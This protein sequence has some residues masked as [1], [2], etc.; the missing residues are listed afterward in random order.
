VEKINKLACIQ[1]ISQIRG[2]QAGRLLIGNRQQPLI[3]ETEK[4]KIIATGY[5]VAITCYGFLK[6]PVSNWVTGNQFFL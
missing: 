1:N 3:E 4:P 5:L 6:K 2:V